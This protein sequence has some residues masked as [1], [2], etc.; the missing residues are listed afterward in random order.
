MKKTNGKLLSPMECRDR[1]F[2]IK[3]NINLESEV[4]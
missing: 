3:M 1:I 4:I 2:I